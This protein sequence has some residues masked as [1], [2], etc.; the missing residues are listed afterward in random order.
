MRFSSIE[1]AVFALMFALMAILAVPV[2]VDYGKKPQPP[3]PDFTELR[4]AALERQIAEQDQALVLMRLMLGQMRVNLEEVREHQ[5][6]TGLR[7]TQEV[8]TA[9]GDVIPGRWEWFV[10]FSEVKP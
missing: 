6:P 10:N 4:I 1:K 8:E 2:V 3:R 5:K 7:Y 9:T